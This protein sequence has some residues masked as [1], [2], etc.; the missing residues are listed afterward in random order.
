MPVNEKCRPPYLRPRLLRRRSVLNLNSVALHPPVRG[1]FPMPKPRDD[2]DDRASSGGAAGMVLI[3][4]G[5]GAL[6]LLCLVGVG[7]GAALLLLGRGP[8]TIAGATNKTGSSP[9]TDDG[10]TVLKTNKIADG[11][12]ISTDTKATGKGKW[13]VRIDSASAVRS[14]DGKQVTIKVNYTLLDKQATDSLLFFVA[15][16]RFGKP[17]TWSIACHWA[18]NLEPGPQTIEATENVVPAEVKTL[19]VFAHGNN[20]DVPK[21]A[22]IQVPV[23]GADK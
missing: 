22:S 11:G 5:A 7:A 20:T 13:S 1:E 21:L 18:V 17:F 12:T 19:E 16:E 2:F 4:L 9:V 15:F 14:K 10:K 3:L 23:T 6:L 8:A